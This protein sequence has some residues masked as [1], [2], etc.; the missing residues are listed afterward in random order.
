MYVI[1]SVLATPAFP[2]Q[3]PD[4][5]PFEFLEQRTP[6]FWA[7]GTGF[8]ED[9]FSR[10]QGGGFMMVRVHHIYYALYFYYYSISSTSGHQELDPGGREPLSWRPSP[11]GLLLYKTLSFYEEFI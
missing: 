2:L 7:P 8:M 4:S 9:S 5:P 10:D 1:T 11:H 6:T 3:F